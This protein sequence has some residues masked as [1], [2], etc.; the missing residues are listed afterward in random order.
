MRIGACEHW[1]LVGLA[2]RPPTTKRAHR[3]RVGGTARYCYFT[4]TVV[5]R[6]VRPRSLVLSYAYRR[7]TAHSALVSLM[8]FWWIYAKLDIFRRVSC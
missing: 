4:R 8:Y 7:Y 1:P 2:A 3:Q 6:I 5:N